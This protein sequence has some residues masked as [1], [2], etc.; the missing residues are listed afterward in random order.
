MRTAYSSGTRVKKFGS[1]QLGLGEEIADVEKALEVLDPPRAGHE[2]LDR[3][4]RQ[5]DIEASAW[6]LLGRG[7]AQCPAAGKL[8]SSIFSLASSG[9]P[10]GLRNRVRLTPL[11]L[12]SP[13][14][15]APLQNRPSCSRSRVRRRICPRPSP[16]PK[17]LRRPGLFPSPSPRERRVRFLER[18]FS[19]IWK[20]CS[21]ELDVA[22]S[23]SSRSSGTEPGSRATSL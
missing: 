16:A 19:C 3:A 23:G 6:S 8:L 9:G 20:Y 15:I 18:S 21:K 13:E 11:R 10:Y 7:R 14:W 5:L 2:D 12:R 1:P 22:Q 17:G 4:V